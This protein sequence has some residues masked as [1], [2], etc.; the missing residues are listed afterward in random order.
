MKFANIR[1]FGSK[2]S[3][4][5]CRTRTV[6]SD[7]SSNANQ[8]SVRR[9]FDL[10]FTVARRQMI[11]CN[12]LLSPPPRLRW[13]IFPGQQTCPQQNEPIREHRH[14]APS[15]SPATEAMT[16]W[17][18]RRN[19][20]RQQRRLQQQLCPCGG[21]FPRHKRTGR[22]QVK[23]AEQSRNSSPA[24]YVERALSMSWWRWI[25]CIGG[26]R[27]GSCRWGKAFYS[28]RLSLVEYLFN[29]WMTLGQVCDRTD[30][31]E[32]FENSAS[33][34]LIA[35]IE[36]KN[37][38][39]GSEIR[40]RG[41]GNDKTRRLGVLP[42][43]GGAPFVECFDQSLKVHWRIDQQARVDRIRTWTRIRLIRE[44]RDN[45]KVATAP[46]W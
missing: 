40:R 37:D 14:P 39:R 46:C 18:I 12:I 44:L 43:G 31:E 42:I 24:L 19:R 6:V 30:V 11:R 38:T 15:G 33:F 13:S 7:Y 3:S 26:R 35:V 16:S 45:S 4:W 10:L 2:Y 25:S 34:P 22:L 28:Q 36:W 41:T 8:R 32:R 29:V 5:P 27:A 1:I 23:H 17:T 9:I 21:T 20:W